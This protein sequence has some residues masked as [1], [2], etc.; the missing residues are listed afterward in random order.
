MST[1][2]REDGA[3]RVP[4]SQRSPAA[5]GPRP[6]SVWKARTLVAVAKAFGVRVSEPVASVVDAPKKRRRHGLSAA[7]QPSCSSL[8]SGC[9][10]S[11]ATKVV[12]EL[13]DDASCITDDDGLAAMEDDAAEDRL[14]ETGE[15]TAS[16]D[17]HVDSAGPCRLR[18]TPRLEAPASSGRYSEYSR[19]FPVVSPR[20]GQSK[21]AP[22][23]H[24]GGHCPPLDARK[25]QF[26]EQIA[27]GSSSWVFRGQYD[28]QDVAIKVVQQLAQQALARELAVLRVANHKNVV[29]VIGAA[30]VGR[31]VC[32][33]SKYMTCS[34]HDFLHRNQQLELRRVLELAHDIAEGMQFLHSQDV[35]HR[36]L[37]TANILLDQDGKAS[38][39]DFGTALMSGWR[40]SHDI[41]EPETYRWMAPEVSMTKLQGHN[42]ACAKSQSTQHASALD[43]YSYGIVLWELL[44]SKLPY[45]EY[46]PMQAA[47]AV[48][49]SGLRPVIPTTCP[50]RL[51]YLI[52]QC[53][54][55][56]PQ[57]RPS[58]RE[59]LQD[60]SSIKS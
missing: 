25:L 31:N 46:L 52:E 57:F 51:R 41:V 15:Q 32:I 2:W 8:A 58:F 21:P 11:V 24:M 17:V 6:V 38:V 19:H 48:I 28:G 16:R 7:R 49:Q 35:V 40:A 27:T 45:D 37:K 30:M 9:L 4:G 18:I 36:D 20:A 43:V 42:A 33:V 44:T 23:P 54:Q 22:F 13:Q 10:Q 26:G 56:N 34:L 3:L 59:I 50:K 29:P 14:R 5:A 12:P 39:A 1:P 47:A 53:W 60:L 55:A